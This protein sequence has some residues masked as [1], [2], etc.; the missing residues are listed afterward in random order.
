MTAL[1]RTCSHRLTDNAGEGVGRTNLMAAPTTENLERLARLLDTGTVTVPIHPSYPLEQ[2][3]A[4]IFSRVG[5]LLS[6]A[7]LQG[8]SVISRCL[9]ASALSRTLRPFAV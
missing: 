7:D 4:A 9:V 8:F 3:A 2:A 1:S 6:L 5:W